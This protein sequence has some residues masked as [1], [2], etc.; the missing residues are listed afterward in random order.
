VEQAIEALNSIDKKDFQ[1]AKS[2]ANPPAGVPDVFIACMFLLANFFTSA[3]DID[4]RSKKPKD[5]NWKNCV[6]MMKSP[7]QFVDTLKA[8]KD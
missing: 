3:I 8:F 6:K 1:T 5:P 2:W 4:P 7:E